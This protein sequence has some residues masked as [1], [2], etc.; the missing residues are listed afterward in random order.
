VNRCVTAKTLSRYLDGDLPPAVSREVQAHL[1]ECRAC[2][3]ALGQ[4]KALDDVVRQAG[5]RPSEAPD[6]AG[7][8]TA[9]LGR[10]GAFLR[11]RITDRK[12][13]LFGESRLTLPVAASLLVAACVV[14]AVL[15]G[16]DH[17][18]RGA[19]NRRTAP[20][21]ADA[22][23][24]LVRLVNVATPDEERARLAWA[25]Q[26]A[27]KLGLPDRLAE[28][29]SGAKPALACDLAYLENTFTLLVREEPLPS[30]LQAELAAGDVLERVVRV[31]DNLQPR[32]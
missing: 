6:V 7:R 10:R 15:A 2:E 9:E 18:S 5:T 3:R 17:A 23:R 19:W 11:A 24:V 31:R 26:E 12:R 14:M 29:R 25:R 20:V 22:E 16:V 1:A 4:M 28:A 27:R 21:V 13:T 30:T 8:V 32:S